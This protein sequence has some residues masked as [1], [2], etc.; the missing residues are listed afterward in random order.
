M[1]VMSVIL[2]AF[3]RD[4]VGALYNQEQITIK[5]NISETR[6]RDVVGFTNLITGDERDNRMI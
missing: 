2:V 1:Q 5:E 4:K 6:G 3:S